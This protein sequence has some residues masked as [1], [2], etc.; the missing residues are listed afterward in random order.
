MRHETLFVGPKGCTVLFHRDG[1]ITRQIDLAAGAYPVRRFL[2]AREAGEWI[3]FGSGK[4]MGKQPQIRSQNFGDRAW[5]SAANPSWRI[6]PSARVARDLKVGMLR[7]NAMGKSVA[8]GIEALKRAK[9]R[10]SETPPAAPAQLMAPA[11]NAEIS[12]T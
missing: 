11:E 5:E 9:S 1:V 12:A 10:V 3:D 7:M 8:K 2:A 4:I 6:S